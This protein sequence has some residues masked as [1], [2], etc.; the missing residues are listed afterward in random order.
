MAAAAAGPPHPHPLPLK[1]GPSVL[2]DAARIHLSRED[3]MPRIFDIIEYPDPAGGE[4]VHRFPEVGS[5]DFR[6]GSQLIVREGQ[7]A[8]FYRDGRALDTFRPG[9]YTLS[10][11][12]IPLL[13]DVV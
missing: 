2:P 13:I 8:V 6:L 7:A 11:N 4:L 3:A 9:R 12:N 5:G 1:R 10:T